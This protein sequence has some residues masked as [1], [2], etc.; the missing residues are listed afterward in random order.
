MRF[1]L[2]IDPIQS[3]DD[4]QRL[5]LM[6]PLMSCSHFLSLTL[7]GVTSLVL[8]YSPCFAQ[9]NDM[10]PT[11]GAAQKR[12]QALQCVGAFAMGTQWMP[13]QDFSA[14]EKAVAKQK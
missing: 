7:A 10:F 14:Y 8:A 3:R 13:C 2:S 11:K 1:F 12:A 6:P 4:K 5:V 9:A